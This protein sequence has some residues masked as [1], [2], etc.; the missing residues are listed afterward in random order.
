MHLKEKGQ[1]DYPEIRGP[2]DLIVA[3][4]DTTQGICRRR[5]TFML[6]EVVISGAVGRSLLTPTA[7][8][9]FYSR[10]GDH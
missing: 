2:D 9:P 5:L 10:L 7:D 4:F 8:E 6:K 3:H 1:F